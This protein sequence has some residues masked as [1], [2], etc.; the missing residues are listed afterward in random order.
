MPNNSANSVLDNK[1]Q[2]IRLIGSGGMGDVYEAENIVIGRR[3]AIKTLK[4]NKQKSESAVTR[5]VREAQRAGTI[6]HDNICEVIDFFVEDDEPYIVMPLLNGSSLREILDREGRLPLARALDI[7]GQVLSALIAAHGEHIVHRDLKPDNIFITRVGDREDFVKVLDFGISKILDA[8]I[9]AELTET[10]VVRGTPYYMAPEQAEGQKEFDHRI[11]IYA[12]GVILY[13]ILTGCRP[14]QGE[15]YNEVLLGILYKP[16]TPPGLLNPQIPNSLQRVIFRAMSRNI[17]ER[18]RSAAAMQS[19]LYQAVEIESARF[20]TSTGGKDFPSAG[21][22]TAIQSQTAISLT[23]PE[24]WVNTGSTAGDDRGSRSLPRRLG[25]AIGVTALI[26]ASFWL[27]TSAESFGTSSVGT[28][29][30]GSPSAKQP[31]KNVKKKRTKTDLPTN[32]TPRI[33]LSSQGKKIISSTNKEMSPQ[34]KPKTAHAAAGKIEGK[35]EKE[36]VSKPPNRGKKRSKT[37]TKP[38]RSKQREELKGPEQTR[39]ILDYRR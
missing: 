38:N 16:V 26:I 12:V 6:G 32:K 22:A 30:D 39:F 15:S 31:E 20:R 24:I 36:R 27:V 8:S 1:Y 35:P 4:K 37:L 25:I 33:D 9:E 23:T 2:L 29:V 17:R 21:R 5:F 10:G 19:A 14:I 28:L 18:Y 7:V 3:V 13:E 34:K 11:D